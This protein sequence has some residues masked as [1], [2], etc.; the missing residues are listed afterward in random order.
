MY[1]VAGICCCN[2]DQFLHS[3]ATYCHMGKPHCILYYQLRSKCL[4]I[5]WDVHNHVPAL[6]TAI[7]LDHHLSYSCSWNGSNPSPEVLQIHI[8]I[9]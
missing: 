4:T 8:H 5:I 1:L 2:R 6:E 9:K 7:L 3:I